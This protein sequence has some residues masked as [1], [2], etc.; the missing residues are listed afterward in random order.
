MAI[1]MHIFVIQSSLD[2]I[3]NYIYFILSTVVLRSRTC[4][5]YVYLF[6][7]CSVHRDFLSGPL[8]CV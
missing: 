6:A 3:R 4:K 1:M 5:K 7:R 8:R 2:M